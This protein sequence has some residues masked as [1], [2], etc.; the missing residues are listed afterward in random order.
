[1]CH[2]SKR[3]KNDIYIVYYISTVVTSKNCTLPR[4]L[5]VLQFNFL[6]TKMSILRISDLVDILWHLRL[7]AF[8]SNSGCFSWL[9]LRHGIMTSTSTL[10]TTHFFFH[11]K[12][13]AFSSKDSNLLASLQVS[14]PKACKSWSSVKM[15]WNWWW[16]ITV[17]ITRCLRPGT[18]FAFINTTT[19]CF[20]RSASLPAR[21]SSDTSKDI[22][23]MVWFFVWLSHSHV[24]VDGSEIRRSPAEVGNLSPWFYQGFCDHPRWLA[25][26]FLNHQQITSEL[27]WPSL[28]AKCWTSRRRMELS[29]AI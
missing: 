12:K 8:F 4:C 1:M 27:S 26:G 6:V 24:T 21:I 5:S 29:Q 3:G 23:S 14:D 22:V 16:K 28:A 17:Q 25:L 19:G 9:F 2:V 10:K 13:P 18:H 11:H 20:F 15:R 7:F